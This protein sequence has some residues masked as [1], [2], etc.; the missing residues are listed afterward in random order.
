MEKEKNVQVFDNFLFP[1]IFETFRVAINFKNLIIGLGA[2]TVICLVGKI[3]DAG[4]TVAATSAGGRTITELHVY[5]SNPEEERPS[6]KTAAQEAGKLETDI[7][8][9]TD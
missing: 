2:I 7:I 6:G 4:G 1:R 9:T 3:M 8:Q 5:L